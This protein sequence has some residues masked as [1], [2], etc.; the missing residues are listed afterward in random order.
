MLTSANRN[1]V[2]EVHKASSVV[3]DVF[4]IEGANIVIR[5]LGIIKDRS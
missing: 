5:Y 2:E 4:Y 1:K 3:S